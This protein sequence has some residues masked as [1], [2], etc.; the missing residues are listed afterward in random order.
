VSGRLELT[1]WRSLSHD[2]VECRLLLEVALA[3]VADDS[4]HAVAEPF[5]EIA[6]TIARRRLSSKPSGEEAAICCQVFRGL[7]TKLGLQANSKL[8]VKT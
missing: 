7:V 1:D 2:A 8:T 4:L 5:R 3:A 6:G